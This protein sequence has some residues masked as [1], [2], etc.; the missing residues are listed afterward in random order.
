MGFKHHHTH[1][2]LCATWNSTKRLRN[3]SKCFTFSKTIYV[4]GTDTSFFCDRFFV[5]HLCAG[6]CGFILKLVFASWLR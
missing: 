1:K 6:P 2:G 3:P 5:F 4:K